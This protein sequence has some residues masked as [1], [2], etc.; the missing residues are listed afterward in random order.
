MS[1]DR[2]AIPL[3]LKRALR[4]AAGFG[5]CFCGNPIFQYHH[6]KQ[7]AASPEH[8]ADN[9]M[10]VC[11]NHH[12]EI[13]VG[14]ITEAE[15]RNAKANPNNIKKGY[16]DGLL[17]ITDPAIAIHAAT[18]DFVGPGFK[19]LVDEKPL[20]AI[21]RGEN[22]RLSISL[23]LYDAT[24]NL[25]LAVVD[26]EWISGDP[27][28]W[29]IE[30]GVRQLKIRRHGGEVVLRLDARRSPATL[31]GDFWFA[32]QHF[33]LR[34]SGLLFNGVVENVGIIELGLVAGRLHADTG[35]GKFRIEPD[36]SFGKTLIVSWPNR[37]QRLKKCFKALAQL[38]AGSTTEVSAN[39]V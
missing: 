32:K 10:V 5:C 7:Y 9:M 33:S 39:A 19:L 31:Y 20:L 15:Q 13:T 12:H 34:E 3:P 14:G 29:D 26:N 27:L 25:L 28:P 1:L 11:P 24:G 8:L 37:K 17:R 38:K 21:D 16:V 2:A 4:Q 30:F 22:G 18:V 36:P 23:D 35:T 6:I